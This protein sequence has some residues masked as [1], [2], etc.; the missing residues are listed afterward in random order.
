ML[1]FWGGTR[2]PYYGVLLSDLFSIDKSRARLAMATGS[3]ILGSILGFAIVKKKQWN[4]GQAELAGFCGDYGLAL[5]TSISYIA[6]LDDKDNKAAAA[7][8][9]LASGAA[10]FWA[11]NRIAKR[12]QFTQGDIYC[13]RSAT[14]L[15]A[16][17]AMPLVRLFGKQEGKVFASA[18]SAGSLAGF[19]IGSNLSA[20]R[21]FTFSEGMLITSGQV[22]GAL[23]G[24][25]V[26]RV[27]AG[28]S[29]A[30]LLY[31]SSMALGSVSGFVLTYHSF[32]HRGEIRH[33]TVTPAKCELVPAFCYTPDR[34]MVPA[35]ALKMEF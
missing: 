9:K 29:E 7:T 24:L 21:S 22:A 12:D 17:I 1:S 27:I 32:A 23:L 13:I 18:M 34:R 10:S 26:A 6:G 2:G 8:L 5:G 35:I 11:A 16:Q 28:D 30:E 19:Y 31:M 25:G 4:L 20:G 15:G 14:V 3:S 33:S